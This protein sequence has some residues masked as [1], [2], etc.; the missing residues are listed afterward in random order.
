MTFN[1]SSLDSFAVFLAVFLGPFWILSS[2]PKSL[3][4]ASTVFEDCFYPL[5]APLPQ[6]LGFCPSNTEVPNTSHSAY[7]KSET[8][9]HSLWEVNEEVFMMRI[10]GCSHLLTMFSDA[11]IQKKTRG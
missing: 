10:A 8:G 2:L 11:K 9:A 1:N 5:F 6:S 3:G 7:C 4:L